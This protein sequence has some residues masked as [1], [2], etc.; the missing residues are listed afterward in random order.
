MYMYPHLIRVIIFQEKKLWYDFPSLMSLVKGGK[1][2]IQIRNLQVSQ[3]FDPISKCLNPLRSATKSRFCVFLS[4]QGSILGFQKISASCISLFP[5]NYLSTF[6]LFDPI[7]FRSAESIN[8]GGFYNYGVPSNKPKQS[9]PVKRHHST[10]DLGPSRIQVCVRKR[11]LSQAELNADEEDIV[12]VTSST[13]VELSVPKLAVD[14]TKYT[15]KVK[16]I[17]TLH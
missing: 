10:S 14:L 15:Q 5:F 1:Y 9:T 12:T 6:S 3:T 16:I 7:F 2:G 11:P 13:A 4:V 8:T 17:F